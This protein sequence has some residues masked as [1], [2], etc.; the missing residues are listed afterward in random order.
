[1]W[2]VIFRRHGELNCDTRYIGPFA[3]FDAAYEH[4]CSLPA[5]GATQTHEEHLRPGVKH[6]VK[7]EL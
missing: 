5:L 7:V 6:I 1:M 4:L 3:N 2:V